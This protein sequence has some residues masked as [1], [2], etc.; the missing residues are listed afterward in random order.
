M[1]CDGVWG[2]VV[3]VFGVVSGQGNDKEGANVLNVRIWV[4][5]SVLEYE[6][7]C[8]VKTPGKIST[9]YWHAGGGARMLIR[10]KILCWKQYEGDV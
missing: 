9:M 5:G 4:E 6:L 10:R 1:Q 2:V 3:E 7:S 8:V